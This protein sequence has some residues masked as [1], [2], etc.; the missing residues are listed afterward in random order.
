MTFMVGYPEYI[1]GWLLMFRKQAKI[2]S[3]Q[4][5]V[6]LTKKMISEL[7]EQYS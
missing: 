2:L 1:A 5:L 4:S 6:D 7:N 3:P